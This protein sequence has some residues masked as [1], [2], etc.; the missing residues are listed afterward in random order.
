[1]VSA[2]LR[3]NRRPKNLGCPCDKNETE[4]RWNRDPSLNHSP[5]P[6]HDQPGIASFSV[7]E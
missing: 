1:M 6:D 7:A 2:K 3:R 5:E 4:L